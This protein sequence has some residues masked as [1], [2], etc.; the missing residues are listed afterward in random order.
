MH[1]LVD[2]NSVVCRVHALG[3]SQPLRDGRRT[4]ESMDLVSLALRATQMSNLDAP[5]I[6][7]TFRHETRSELE[8]TIFS[9][10]HDLRRDTA[11]E[12][13]T[14]SITATRIPAQEIT[15]IRSQFSL[16]LLYLRNNEEDSEQAVKQVKEAISTLDSMLIG[17]V[18]TGLLSLIQRIDETN[19]IQRKQ[20]QDRQSTQEL[21][22]G[23][24]VVLVVPSIWLGL[25]GTNILPP[26]VVNLS[27]KWW[28]GAAIIAATV[29]V[30]WI[31]YATVRRVVGTKGKE[32]E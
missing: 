15:D 16:W 8:L 22:A 5:E 18:D 19:E 27:D 6:Q 26:Q 12:S 11:T 24:A 28:F 3:P 23:I 9:D 1:V 7:S 29:P 14:P 31:F 20:D 13:A 30:T 2:H 21:L 25:W 17:A 32:L 4:L 10:L